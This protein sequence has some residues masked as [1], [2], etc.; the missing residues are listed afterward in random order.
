MTLAAEEWL[1][2]RAAALLLG[3]TARRYRETAA[4]PVLVAASRAFA[5]MTLGA[6]AGLAVDIDDGGV[7]RIVGVRGEGGPAAGERVM[8]GGMSEGTRDQLFLA[9]R[10][11]AIERWAVDRPAPP[12]IVDDLFASFDDERLG[13]GLDALAELGATAQC[14]VFTHHPHLVRVAEE[15]LGDAAHICRLQVG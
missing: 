8:I 5:A 11:A 3:E 9:L 7:E 13:A 6:F 15:R 12:F 10:L 1:T 14:L 2:L 4:N